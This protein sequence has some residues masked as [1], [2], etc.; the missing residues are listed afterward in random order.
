[1][2]SNSLYDTPFKAIVVGAPM[3]TQKISRPSMQAQIAPTYCTV[4]GSGL[5]P[6][7]KAARL[8][9]RSPRLLSRWVED[10]LLHF[11]ELADGCLM[12]CGHTLAAQVSESESTANAPAGS[13]ALTLSLEAE[14]VES[15]TEELPGWLSSSQIYS[16]NTDH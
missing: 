12:V 16:T 7:E 11:R 13:E 14:V 2:N 4:C 5:L 8:C 6:L 9:Q 3:V 1:M 15:T 10:G